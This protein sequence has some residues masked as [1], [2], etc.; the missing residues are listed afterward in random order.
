MLLRFDRPRTKG[1][2][3]SLKGET[4]LDGFKNQFLLILQKFQSEIDGPLDFISVERSDYRVQ[5]HS[6]TP[7]R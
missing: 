7:R 1:D 2:F 6:P 3:R 4:T 5:A